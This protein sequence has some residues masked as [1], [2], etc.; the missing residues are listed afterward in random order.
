METKP[1]DFSPLRFHWRLGSFP[2]RF[3]VS[4]EKGTIRFLFVSYWFLL[5]S[6]FPPY[7][8]ETRNEPQSL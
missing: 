6:C 8:V 1:Y 5:V 7:T 2:P 3:H 4:R